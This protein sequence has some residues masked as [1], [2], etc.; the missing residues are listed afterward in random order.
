[1]PENP[2]IDAIAALICS[3]KRYT[4]D[5]SYSAAGAFKRTY[6]VTSDQSVALALKIIVG[7]IDAARVRREIE[8]LG[9]C[10]H[11]HIVRLVETSVLAHD[12]QDW[13]YLV[14]EFLP[15][16]TLTSKLAESGRMPAH[17]AM[18]FARDLSSAIEHLAEMRIVHRDIKPDN[19]MYRDAATAVLVDLGIA[20]HLDATAL[21]ADG[22]QGP[23][24]P[25]F[26]S[27]EQL[28]SERDLIDWRCDQYSLGVV[29]SL[30]MLG[31]YPATGTSEPD[32]TLVSN[33]HP[34][35]DAFLA[36][37]EAAGVPQLIKMVQ[38]WPVQRFAR[39]QLLV[40]AWME[41]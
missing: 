29:I 18:A 24:T 4:L 16:G 17:A 21:T 13:V 3:E 6:R 33:R 30:A 37:A 26:A 25:P 12:G 10:N 41:T 5:P 34:P 35:A 9:R 20:R 36:A 15:G 19:I 11:V 28:R 39:P 38:P 31:I 22:L 7:R 14:E 1:V 32:P 2:Q 27:P 23:M 40:Q 8:A